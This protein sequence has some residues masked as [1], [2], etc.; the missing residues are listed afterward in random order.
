MREAKRSAILLLGPTGAGKT[1]LG[2]MLA[3]RGL[4]GRRCLHFDFGAC[5]R[6]VVTRRQP[7]DIVSKCDIEFL[8][9]VLATGALLEDKD[10]PIAERILRSFLAR[11]GAGLGT[12]TVLNGLPRHIGQARDLELLLRVEAVI[13]LE[14]TPATV[15]AR[16]AANTGGDRDCRVDDGLLHVRR[17]LSLFAARTAPLIDFYQRSGTKMLNVAVTAEMSPLRMW[18]MVQEI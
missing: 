8:D 17:K 4:G 12:L 3:Q 9:G 5:L 10:F 15:L 6:E 7:D 11:C 13:Q 1:P 16:I 2:E 14:C 18:E